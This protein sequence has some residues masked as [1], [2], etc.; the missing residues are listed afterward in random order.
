[1]R[2]ATA[3]NMAQLGPDFKQIGITPN[4]SKPEIDAAMAAYAADETS[5]GNY[6][7]VNPRD[8]RTTFGIPT[9]SNILNTVLPNSYYDMNVPEQ[10][11][12][13]SKMGYRGPTIFGA[14]DSG[15]QKDIFGRNIVS[16]L[17]NYAKKQQRD[18]DKLD[19]YFGSKKF[20]EKYGFKGSDFLEVD[21]E[22]NYFFDYNIPTDFLGTR[23]DPNYMNRLNLQ[24]YGRMYHLLL[25]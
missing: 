10:I 17:G 19:D 5:I 7:A 1:M 12:T 3:F 21:E 9:L 22:G 20:E 4:M 16:G 18:I 23:R 25:I 6:P 15:L 13:Q 11:Y 24:R 8:V 14:N 2:D